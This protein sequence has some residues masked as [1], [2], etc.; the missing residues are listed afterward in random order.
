MTF[1]QRPKEVR[2]PARGLSERRAFQAEG[3]ASAKAL[4]WEGA[5]QVHGQKGDQ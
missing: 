3:I 2:E 1:E 4:R 5:W